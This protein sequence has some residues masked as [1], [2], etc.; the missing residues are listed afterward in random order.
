MDLVY[1]ASLLLALVAGGLSAGCGA[2]IWIAR[3]RDWSRRMALK[4][5]AALGGII[6]LVLGAAS[7]GIHFGFDHRPGSP[8]A[9]D[10]LAF[11][12]AHPA[13][14]LVLAL[15]LAGLLTVRAGATASH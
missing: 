5:A 4:R 14:L 7:A 12:R 8:Q 15:A 6:A 3:H 10:V 9:M 1:S 2:V 13:Y 11:V